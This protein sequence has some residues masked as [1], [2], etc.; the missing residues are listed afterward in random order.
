MNIPAL[1]FV[2]TEVPRVP[3]PAADEFNRMAANGSEPAVLTGCLQDWPLVRE[4]QQAGNPD[5]EI[6]VLERLIGHRK[7]QYTTI[8]PEQ[9]GQ[10]GYTDDGSRTNF[11]FTSG[12]RV[13]FS[14]F[15]DALRATL[16]DRRGGAVYM[17]SAP[18]RGFPE[19]LPHVPDL[20]YLATAA[21]AYRQLWIGSGGHVVNLHF[22]PTHNLIA[23]LTGRKRVTLIPPDSMT[24]MY[25]APLDVRLGD[26]IGSQ[27]T[28]LAPDFARHP[29]AADE[30]AKARVAILEP[31]EILYIPP[32]WWHHVESFGLNVMLNKWVLPV[33]AA[34]FTDLTVD[35]VRGML[36][37]SD[38]PRS[39][40]L[41]YREAYAGAL[42]GTAEPPASPPAA[43]DAVTGRLLSR[44]DRQMRDSCRV[45]RD[46]PPA[47]R[48]RLPPLYDYYVFQVDGAPSLSNTDPAGFRR[49]LRLYAGAVSAIRAA[50][51]IA[52]LPRRRTQT[53]RKTCQ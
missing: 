6:A 45:L 16:A 10:L 19:L 43:A 11:A 8:A 28:L 1:T 5:A 15:G 20:Q 23:M 13:A 51:S 27:V 41:R 49:K 17:Q 7:V 12:K 36:L 9:H 4:L 31:G 25:P 42:F 2:H 37:F 29:R 44:A 26:A 24:N 38:I 22:D 46:V 33:P 35:L 39:L 34:H 32:M 30:L 21:E 18:L 50:Q 48:R 47:L 3:A 53:D 40:R 52:S 14:R